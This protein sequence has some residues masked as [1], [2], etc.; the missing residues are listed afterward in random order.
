MVHL[1]QKEFLINLAKHV[2]KTKYFNRKQICLEN[3]PIF[4]Q[5]N[6]VCI[7]I[8]R[9]IIGLFEFYIIGLKLKNKK[10]TLLSHIYRTE[11]ISV[12]I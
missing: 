11:Y 3:L 5:S 1:F 4:K 9:I 12:L 7:N 2:Y 8:Y 10:Y 6:F